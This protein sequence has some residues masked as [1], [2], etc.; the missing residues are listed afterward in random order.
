VKTVIF[1]IRL[2]Y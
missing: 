2:N 1:T